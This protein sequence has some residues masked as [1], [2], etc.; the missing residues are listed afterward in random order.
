M[1]IDDAFAGQ[2]LAG[3]IHA[4][5][6]LAIPLGTGTVPELVGVV[7]TAEVE[8]PL[9]TVSSSDG[10]LGLYRSSS[11]NSPDAIVDYVEWGSSNHARSGVAVAAGI[12][13]PGGFVEV[14]AELLAI[15]T[16]A[17][18]TEAPEDWFAEIGG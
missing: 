3:G 5:Q 17:F 16:Q 9:G 11:F 6:R 12:W 4:V 8:R 18:P 1:R 10:E 14:P 13:V 2:P 15:V 7:A